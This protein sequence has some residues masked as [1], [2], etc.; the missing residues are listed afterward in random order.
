MRKNKGITLLALIVTIIIML[1]LAGVT[2]N[3]GFGEAGIFSNTKKAV[4]DTTIAKAKEEAELK[5]AKFV[6]DY[7]KELVTDKTA[8]EYVE[9]KM[10]NG[11]RDS[12]W[13][14]FCDSK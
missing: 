14:V 1:I 13:R 3:L 11:I 12:I 7:H 9:E 6:I 2:I 5:I 10:E 4:S 8:S